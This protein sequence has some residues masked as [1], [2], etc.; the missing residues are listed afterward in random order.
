MFFDDLIY[1]GISYEAVLIFY[2][3]LHLL[4]V[5]ELA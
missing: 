2:L 3:Q 5:R 4:H 1:V